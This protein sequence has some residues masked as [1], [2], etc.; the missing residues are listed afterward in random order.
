MDSRYCLHSTSS[1]SSECKD[2][3]VAVFILYLVLVHMY[4][5]SCIIPLTQALMHSSKDECECRTISF[6]LEPSQMRS[7]CLR[8]WLPSDMRGW[9]VELDRTEASACGVHLLPNASFMQSVLTLTFICVSY[10]NT[11][12]HLQTGRGSCTA[13]LP[14]TLHSSAVTQ[15][16]IPLHYIVASCHDISGAK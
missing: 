4:T 3:I 1:T 14:T 8:S 10:F 11:H 2:E 12:R 16:Y 9:T 6:E 15:L 7:L 5:P 13:T